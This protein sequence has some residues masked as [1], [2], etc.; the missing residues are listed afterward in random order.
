MSHVLVKFIIYGN[1]L[2]R[3]VF[4]AVASLLT[5]IQITER[6]RV[7]PF[8]FNRR[9]KLCTLYKKIRDTG[10]IGDQ[11]MSFRLDSFALKQNMYRYTQMARS[12]DENIRLVCLILSL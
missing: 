12:K 8:L 3:I 5:G 10:M 11:T 1:F 4:F 9:A 2:F 6:K 7:P